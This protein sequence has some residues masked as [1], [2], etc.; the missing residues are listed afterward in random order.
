[1]A[2]RA[3]LKLPMRLQSATPYRGAVSTTC[4]LIFRWPR[5]CPNDIC[6]ISYVYPFDDAGIVSLAVADPD[7]P[8]CHQGRVAGARRRPALAIL[9]FEE[10]EM[11]SNAPSTVT[12][13][14]RARQCR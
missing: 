13:P 5:I 11:L 8:G 10:V 9:S 1:M 4:W 6:G 3:R 14:T 12:N 7:A 2:W